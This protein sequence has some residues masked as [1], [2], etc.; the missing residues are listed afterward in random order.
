MRLRFVLSPYALQ[1]GKVIASVREVFG[2]RLARYANS[3]KSVI[4]DCNADRFVQWLIARDRSGAA[5]SFKDL[6]LEILSPEPKPN[7]ISFD[8]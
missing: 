3:T 4:V 5:N 7:Y 1:S 2:E 8:E 6:K